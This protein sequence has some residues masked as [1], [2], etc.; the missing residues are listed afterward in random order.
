MKQEESE[1]DDKEDESCGPKTSKS[2][3]KVKRAKSVK[4]EPKEEKDEEEKEDEEVVTKKSKSN[5]KK[6][7]PVKEEP[8]EIIKTVKYTGDIP[9]DEKFTEVVGTHYKIYKENNVPFECMLN[10]VFEII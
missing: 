4:K 2:N 1:N 3:G 6:S 9:L 7:A 10:Q 5:A 8:E